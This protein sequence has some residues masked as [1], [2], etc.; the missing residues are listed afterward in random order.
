MASAN[1]VMMHLKEQHIQSQIDL[2]KARTTAAQTGTAPADLAKLPSGTP[3][4]K[5]EA[6]LATLD[7]NTAQLVKK[8]ANYELPIS[9]F[10]GLDIKTRTR[11]VQLAALYDPSFDVKE[12]QTRTKVQADYS[13]AGATGRNIIAINTIAYHLDQFKKAYEKLDNRQIKLWNTAQ[14][15]LKTNFGDPTITAVQV[16]ANAIADEM[17]RIL[18]GGTASPTNEDTELWQSIYG[19]SMSKAQMQAT[20]W[21]SFEVAGGRLK[22]IS[23]AYERA[24]GKPRDDLWPDTKAII[25]QNKPRNEPT[26]SW[27]R[28]TSGTN[29]TGSSIPRGIPSGSKRTERTIKGKPAWLAPDG[30]YYPEP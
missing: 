24:M 9:G 6:L 29:G 14:N 22:Q 8:M 2:N 17:A 21:Q 30:M 7:P 10:G 15:K 19:T 13:P 18:K 25:A 12:M 11:L 27:L 28:D 5:N 20:I 16:P 4:Q 26:P 3:G 23:T 1:P